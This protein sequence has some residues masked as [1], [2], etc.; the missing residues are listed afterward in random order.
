MR[1]FVKVRL[2][3]GRGGRVVILRGEAGVPRP[4]LFVVAED[5]AR[6]E[7]L[8]R[9]L[10]R[11]YD[12]D[13]DVVGAAAA[14]T[15]MTMLKDL[16][17]TGA[18]VAL[19]IAHERLAEIPAVGL[20]AR[21]HDLHPGAKRILL[22][23]RGDWSAA[24]PAV[25]AMATGQIDYHLY[26]PWRPAERILYP[27][28]SEFLAAWDKSRE[29]ASAAFRI[30]GPAHSPRSHQLRDVL[31]RTGVPYW[32]FEDDSEEGRQLLREFALDGA[33][34][35]V[36][37][38][39]DGTVLVDPS[40]GELMNKLGVRTS[41]D[42][43]DCDVAI[44]G[45]GP[46]GLAAAVYAA[47]EGLSTLVLE[48]AVPGGQAGTSSLI[49]NYLGFQR[50]ISGEDLTNR[51]IEQAWLFGA[52]MVITRA[53]GLTAQG[54]DRIVRTGDGSQVAARAVIIAT[55][56]TWRRLGVPALEA[57]VGAGVFYGAAGAEA[58]AMAGRDVFVVGAGNSAG[59]AAIHLA[60]YASSVT[61]VV[62]GPGLSPS[63]SEYLITEISNTSNIDV[64]PGTEVIDGAG[65]STLETLILRDKATGTT[66]VPASALFLMIG[67][68]PHTEWLESSV[69]RDDR[70]FILTGRDL[71]RAGQLPAGWPLERP[72]LL[73]ETSMPGVFAAGDVRHRSMKRVASAV[74]E[75][76]TA[77]QLVHEYLRGDE[78]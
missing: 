10:Q 69:E 14:A 16:T 42:V 23:E 9:D 74:G 19:L 18:E 76:A 5:G 21:A 56:V 3:L 37:V 65:R 2:V 20:L 35:P 38:H 55:G 78:G 39:Y 67:A 75:G 12:A 43:Q 4:V 48:P 34:L 33:R 30:V 29:P 13:Y 47:S 24:H 49:R 51:A 46:A 71:Y 54:P 58:L 7:A 45:A 1:S 50:G 6:L 28:M 62:R 66:Q 26:A 31:S 36:A 63:M 59:Q 15:A 41:P 77:I 68:E 44:I 70:G 57:L 64:R 17:N 25:T 27:A 60:K 40:H 53:T 72:P 8:T 61:M 32:F 22:I 11:R 73:L 52:N